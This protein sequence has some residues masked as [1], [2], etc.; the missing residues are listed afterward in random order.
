MPGARRS[1]VL[2][3]VSDDY[4]A[5]DGC[6]ETS[7]TLHIW[8][9]RS[10]RL[11]V[12]RCNPYSATSNGRFSSAPNSGNRLIVFIESPF[13]GEIAPSNCTGNIHTAY[14][15]GG[16]S[17]VGVVVR[18]RI[19]DVRCAETSPAG[20]PPAHTSPPFAI[21]SMASRMSSDKSGHTRISVANSGRLATICVRSGASRASGFALAVSEISVLDGANGTCSRPPASIAPYRLCVVAVTTRQ[22][23]P[24]MHATRLRAPVL[25]LL[26]VDGTVTSETTICQQK[27]SSLLAHVEPGNRTRRPI[28]ANA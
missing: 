23:T 18:C 24:R 27:E 21:L 4:A 11:A 28:D 19:G 9:N 3:C 12:R 17:P 2:Q 22:R 7:W 15:T 6:C 20:S 26:A 25:Q 13:D 1:P 8:G 5:S 10:D 14:K 16:H